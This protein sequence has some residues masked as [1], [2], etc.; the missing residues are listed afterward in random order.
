MCKDAAW[1]AVVALA[2]GLGVAP[3][4]FAQR[5]TGTLVG[6]VTDESGAVLPGVT[7]ALKGEAVVGTQTDVS[8]PQGVYRFAALPPGTY[9]VT[10]TL[11]GFSTLRRSGLRVPVGA[12]VEENVSLKVSQMAEEVTV[13]GESTVVDT[14]TN[15]VSTNYD[16]EWV[17]NAPVPRFTFFDLINAAP[18]VNQAQTGDSRS[19]SLGSAGSENS[20]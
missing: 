10:F 5:T 15:Q 1:L 11:A 12:T 3:Q 20:Y 8:G 7:V 16:K 6:T 2:V 4:A 18:G 9:E 19:T 17:R 13:S 14:T